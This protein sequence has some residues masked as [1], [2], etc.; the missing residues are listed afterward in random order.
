MFSTIFSLAINN[1]PHSRSQGSGVLC[2]AIVGGAVVPPLFGLV[3]DISGFTIALF[4][5]AICYAYIALY[6][7]IQKQAESDA[8]T[9][10]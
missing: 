10:G 2:A 8:S 6:G 1:M 9:P 7:F 3:T 5:P 4:L